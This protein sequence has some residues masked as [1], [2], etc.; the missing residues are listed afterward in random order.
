[1][2]R[3]IFNLLQF[4][5]SFPEP[6]L[7]TKE[8]QAQIRLF[9][10]NHHQTLSLLTT[11]HLFSEHKSVKAE[12]RDCLKD[13]GADPSALRK[14]CRLNSSRVTSHGYSLI[15]IDCFNRQISLPTSLVPYDQK[16]GNRFAQIIIFESYDS[17]TAFQIHKINIPTTLP[18]P[19]RAS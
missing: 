16:V 3:K 15:G 4:H 7:I 12:E 1:M 9:N 14:I 17:S 2:T 6:S 10:K 13:Q 18:I 11:G 8:H 19:L 5:F